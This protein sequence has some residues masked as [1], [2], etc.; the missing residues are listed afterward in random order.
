MAER[1]IPKGWKRIDAYHMTRGD[2]SICRIYIGGVMIWELWDGTFPKTARC[3][4]R[5]EDSDGGFAKCIELA[6]EPKEAA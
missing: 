4:F 1:S 5:C 6:D 3:R 2:Q